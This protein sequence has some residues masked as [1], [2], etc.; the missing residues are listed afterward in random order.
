MFEVKFLQNW[1]ALMVT[2]FEVQERARLK[3]EN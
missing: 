2:K 1:Y 3:Y